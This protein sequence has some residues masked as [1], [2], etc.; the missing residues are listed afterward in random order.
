MYFEDRSVCRSEPICSSH[1]LQNVL[2]F[3]LFFISMINL[4]YLV[5]IQR[6]TA[7]LK[8]FN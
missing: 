7:S 4:S 3:T 2:L 8:S 5:L 1:L 6:I